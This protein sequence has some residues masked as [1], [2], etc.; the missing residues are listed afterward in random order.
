MTATK[1]LPSITLPCPRCGEAS[2]NIALN[3]WSLEDSDSENLHCTECE[4]DISLNDVR[5]FIDRWTAILT[6]I[7]AAPTV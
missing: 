5:S 7:E 4:N 3:L 2:A 1:T 6:W